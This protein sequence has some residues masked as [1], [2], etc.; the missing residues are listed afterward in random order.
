MYPKPSSLGKFIPKDYTKLEEEFLEFIK[1]F[2]FNVYDI[3]IRD[4]KWHEDFYARSC[5]HNVH[6]DNYDGLGKIERQLIWSNDAATVFIGLPWFDPFDVVLYSSLDAH[7]GPDKI[8][9]NRWFLRGRILDESIH[10][11]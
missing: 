9:S 8:N 7:K 11:R 1:P 2:N 3:E 6:V 10:T 4:P 5:L